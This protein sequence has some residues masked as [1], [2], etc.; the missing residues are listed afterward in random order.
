MCVCVCV[1]IVLHR[2]TVLMYENS[3]VWLDT[4][5]ASSW[6]RKPPNFTLDLVSNP[7]AFSVTYVSSGMITHLYSLLFV[8]ILHYWISECSIRK[9]YFALCRWQPLI[10]S[11]EYPAAGRGAYILSST[12]SF[13]VSQLFSVTKHTGRF[14]LG[15]T[16]IEFGFSRRKWTRQLEFKF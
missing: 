2:Q 11:P 1:C 3:S 10:P 6:D 15:Y 8:S 12:D 9:K 5:D 13:V 7:S 14:K 16:R 4:Q